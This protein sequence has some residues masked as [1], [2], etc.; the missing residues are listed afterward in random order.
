MLLRQCDD[1]LKGGFWWMEVHLTPL[2]TDWAVSLEC[3]CKRVGPLP[4]NLG[5]R[6]FGE[7]TISMAEYKGLGLVTLAKMEKWPS[8]KKGASKGCDISE[9]LRPNIWPTWIL[10]YGLQQ[11]QM[12]AKWGMYQGWHQE[13]I[14]T[15][16]E[17]KVELMHSPLIGLP[18]AN[19]VL[20]AIYGFWRV[21]CCG[22]KY[23][24]WEA[25]YRGIS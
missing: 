17:V 5:V 12:L 11:F 14:T 16:S 2:V 6:G 19:N 15:S 7:L 13:T 20:S 8:Q 25:R 23:C 9:Q 3:K 21:C 4:T 22:R 10:S 1:Q 18:K 24:F